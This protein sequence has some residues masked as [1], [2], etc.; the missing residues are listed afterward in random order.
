MLEE[1]DYDDDNTGINDPEIVLK[2][3]KIKTWLYVALLA[4]KHRGWVEISL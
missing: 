3:Q 2:H 1:D 4:G